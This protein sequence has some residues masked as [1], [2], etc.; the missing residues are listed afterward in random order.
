MKQNE[1]DNQKDKKSNKKVQ[2]INTAKEILEMAY[3]DDDMNCFVMNDESYMDL[4]LITQKIWLV[5]LIMKL[6][7]TS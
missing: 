5:Q 2:I 4:I 3:Y 7:M 1:K 6:S